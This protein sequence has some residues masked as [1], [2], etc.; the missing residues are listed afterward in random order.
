MTLWALMDDADVCLDADGQALVTTF[1]HELDTQRRGTER[2]VAVTVTE[3]GQ[4]GPTWVCTACGSREG[5][6]NVNYAAGD[7]DVACNVCDS[8]EVEDSIDVALS[9][10]VERAVNAEARAEAARLGVACVK[11]ELAQCQSDRQREHE[12]RVRLAGEVEGLTHQAR[13]ARDLLQRTERL[14]VSG[15]LEYPLYRDISTF[16]ALSEEEGR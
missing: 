6:H 10:L 14:L 4:A 11:A 8:V 3:V 1:R 9:R 7:A 2:V 5:F 13:V 15:A 16:L 12:A